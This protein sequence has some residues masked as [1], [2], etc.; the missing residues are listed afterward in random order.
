MDQNLLELLE[1]KHNIFDHLLY[2][3]EMYLDTFDALLFYSLKT[4]VSFQKN[5]LLESHAVHLRNLIEFLNCE[6]DCI[7]VNSIFIGNYDLS[8]DDSLLNAKQTI[9]KTIEHLTEERTKWNQTDKD[10]TIHFSKVV[11]EMH[12][13]MV[14]RIE[15]CIVMLFN[16]TDINS[17]YSSDL[18]DERIQARIKTLEKRVRSKNIPI[19]RV[20]S[21]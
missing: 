15:R 1:R 12:P 7:C 9:N 6:K 8:F 14:E 10:L 18:I 2:E 13:I 11:N 21:L 16:K 19:L 5:V 20:Y 17:K 4:N 3:F